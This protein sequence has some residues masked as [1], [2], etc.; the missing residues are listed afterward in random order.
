LAL[1]TLKNN[2]N[3]DI[4]KDFFEQFCSYGNLPKGS[5]LLVLHDNSLPGKNLQ[6]VC[7]T[8]QLICFASEYRYICSCSDSTKWDCCIAIDRKWCL[9]RDKFP[10]YFTYLLG[11][12]FGHAYICLSDITLHI[13]HCLIHD[14]IKPASKSVIQYEHELPS[15]QLFDQFGKYLSFK[16][17]G[18]KKLEHEINLLKKTANNIEKLR[19]KMIKE[20]D[21]KNDFTGLRKSIIE[22]SKPYKSE[23]IQCW[24]EDY[25]NRGSRSLTSLISD[26][27][28][29]F[30]Y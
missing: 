23:L 27:D 28:E 26:Y 24:N 15:E 11:H 25:E 20:L 30:E 9:S 29:L 10:A 17:H 14:W 3:I 12:E 2:E 4:E 6:G 22:F 1:V 7:V 16:L 13:H 5:I 21:P 8:S 18:D 19:L